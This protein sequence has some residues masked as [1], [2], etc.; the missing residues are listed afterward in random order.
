MNK[1]KLNQRVDSSSRINWLGNWEQP[2][3]EGSPNYVQS[4]QITR[5]LTSSSDSIPMSKYVVE[6]SPSVPL[7]RGFKSAR[8][9][10]SPTFQLK[11][12]NPTQNLIPKSSSSSRIVS[13][14]RRGSAVCN[15][16]PFTSIET[17][18]IQNKPVHTGF[19]HLRMNRSTRSYTPQLGSIQFRHHQGNS[20]PLK[21]DISIIIRKNP[22]VLLFASFLIQI[23][24]I[25]FTL[26][27]QKNFDIFKFDFFFFI[28]ILKAI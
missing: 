19:E 23:F 18:S 24:F 28:R 12:K 2:D 6:G 27:T 8:S 11:L 21:T 5:I 7:Q 17:I 13:N 3:H 26:K 15:A 4:S 10:M 20:S 9:S 1:C 22:K 14:S 25:A 16:S